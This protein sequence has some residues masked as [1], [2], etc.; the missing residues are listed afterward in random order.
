[1][2]TGSHVR[3]W[4][5]EI[6]SVDVGGDAA[7]SSDCECWEL[8]LSTEEEVVVVVVVE[9]VEEEEAEDVEAEVVTDGAGGLIGA[10][11]DVV[12][13]DRVGLSEGGGN[14]MNEDGGGG[15]GEARVGMKIALC[16]PPPKARH[17]WS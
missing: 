2:S 14:V 5:F 7:M 8:F 10:L 17:S 12:M 15:G 6:G 13:E 11:R 4:D 9:L 16:W 3:S 1:M